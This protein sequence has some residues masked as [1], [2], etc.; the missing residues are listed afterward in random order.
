MVCL[1]VLDIDFKMQMI[2]S[3]K[4]LDDASGPA[5]TFDFTNG[6]NRSV[7]GVF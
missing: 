7:Y 2:I 1:G 5:E 6:K 4:K 3:C